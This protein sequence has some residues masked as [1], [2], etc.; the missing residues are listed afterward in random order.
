MKEY[1]S[2]WRLFPKASVGLAFLIEILFVFI[3]T[4]GV[5]LL[6][7]DFQ[8][9]CTG[10]KFELGVILIGTFCVILMS[11][12]GF[13]LACILTSAFGNIARAVLHPLRKNG[14]KMNQF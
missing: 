10:S 8:Q 3:G 14:K 7:Q 12:F 5:T 2:I 9:F 4:Q 1:F 11:T 13:Q 6:L